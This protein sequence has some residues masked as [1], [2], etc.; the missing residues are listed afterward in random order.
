MVQER[1]NIHTTPYVLYYVGDE[2]NA[3][4]LRSNQRAGAAEPQK[5]GLRKDSYFRKV[6]VHLMLVTFC[7]SFCHLQ[8]QYS[9]QLVCHMKSASSQSL[10]LLS[11]VSFA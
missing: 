4:A 3:G 5:L 11:M 7:G 8:L 9:K 1:K 2:P 6:F 10:V